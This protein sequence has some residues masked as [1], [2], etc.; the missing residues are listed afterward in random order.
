MPRSTAN[1]R[2]IAEI[3]ARLLNH[4]GTVDEPAAVR[5]A[6]AED[7]LEDLREFAPGEVQMA[8]RDWR[9]TQSLRPTIAEIR[10]LAT[11][12]QHHFTE[13][14]QALEEQPGSLDAETRRMWS[15]PEYYGDFRSPE[16]RRI[17]AIARNNERY[18]RGAAWRAG[19]LDEYDAIH[20][21]ERLAERRRRGS[22]SEPPITAADFGVTASEQAAE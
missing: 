22:V 15:D 7:W 2:T 11:K 16:Q 13:Q 19:K 1:D 6:I 12:A 10:A 4:F 17:D 14:L 20:H 18:R 9:Q 8:A 3:I 21:P 5:K